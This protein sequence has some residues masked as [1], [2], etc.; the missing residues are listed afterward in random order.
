MTG[1]MIGMP[2]I[3]YYSNPKAVNPVI[4][5]VYFINYF[6][7]AMLLTQGSLTRRRIGF[8]MTADMIGKPI[9]KYYSNPKVVNPGIQTVSFIQQ[10][11][12]LV[13]LTP[14]LS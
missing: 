5:T 4:R 14:V 8:E 3:K 7:G 9:I 2:I 10:I 6:I 11:I 13:L 12:G 1:D